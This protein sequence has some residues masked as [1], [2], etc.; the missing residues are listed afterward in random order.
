M[1]AIHGTVR[2]ST[3]EVRPDA[4]VLIDS[5]PPHP[6]VGALTD[7]EGRFSLSGLRRGSYRISAYVNGVRGAT[8][9]VRLTGKS[10]AKIELVL[11]AAIDDAR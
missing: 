11:D 4:T 2:M 1:G 7:R 5:G 6:D 8:Q 9:V 10:P 3:G